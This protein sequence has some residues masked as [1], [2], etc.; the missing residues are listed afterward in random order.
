MNAVALLPKS[1]STNTKNGDA[2]NYLTACSIGL[3]FGALQLSDWIGPSSRST[4]SS[5]ARAESGVSPWGVTTT[6][7]GNVRLGLRSYPGVRLGLISRRRRK[8]PLFLSPALHCGHS[9]SA[10][11]PRRRRINIT[12]G[13]WAGPISTRSWRSVSR[14]APSGPPAA[15]AG[16]ECTPHSTSCQQCGEIRTRWSTS[17]TLMELAV[18]TV[19]PDALET[20]AD[21]VAFTSVC[22]PSGRRGSMA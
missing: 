3:G 13:C 19:C 20:L 17:V 5:C 10:S 1:L 2:I 12:W 11:P 22:F 7:L 14:I 18:L 8:A 6:R 21:S 16:I 4:S 9:S 15:G